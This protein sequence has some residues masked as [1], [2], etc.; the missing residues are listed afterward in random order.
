MKA[1]HLSF[2]S[3][4]C[5][6]ALCSTSF[7]YTI[8]G[9]VKDDQG[10][11]L[12]DVSVSLLK[13][14]KTATTD[15]DGKF[16]KNIITDWKNH[17]ILEKNDW[18]V[19]EKFGVY[20]YHPVKDRKPYTF[21]LNELLLNNEDVGEEM[22]RVMVFKN[23]LIIQYLDDFD[24]VTCYNNKQAKTLYD[25]LEKDI[26]KLNKKYIIFMGETKAT[27]I[28]KWLDKMEDK[29]GWKRNSLMHKTTAY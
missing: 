4:A 20:G 9:T 23:K 5:I 18:L 11:A 6:A 8:E 15:K 1:K 28:K 22:R 25:K 27:N 26:S 19:E 12:K 13:E 14:G 29:T 2:L 16:T 21:I 24:F 7:A 10:K 3:A 17:I